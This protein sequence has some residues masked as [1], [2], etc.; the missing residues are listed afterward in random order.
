MMEVFVQRL[1]MN[2]STSI[3]HTFI[4]CNSVV[5]FVQQY[6]N[7]VIMKITNSILNNFLTDWT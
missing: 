3:F 1:E 4:Y 7:T 6:T 5:Y 2:T